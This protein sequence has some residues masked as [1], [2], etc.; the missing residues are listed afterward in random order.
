MEHSHSII[1]FNA[2]KKEWN[3]FDRAF[4][5]DNVFNLSNIYP[6]PIDFIKTSK[7]LNIFS[8]IKKTWSQA[9][10]RI[11]H[12][13]SKISCEHLTNDKVQSLIQKNTKIN[14][15]PIMF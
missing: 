7:I 2:T 10:D 15:Q 12:M 13:H 1:D 14:K 3:Y 4:Y 8:N 6:N 9:M 11:K 5:D